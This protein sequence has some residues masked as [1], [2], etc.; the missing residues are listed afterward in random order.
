MLGRLILLFTLVPLVEL[1]LLIKIGT[2]IGALP[3]VLIVVGTG[4]L[5]AYLSRQQGFMVWSRIQRE[6]EMGMFP[7]E[8]MLDGLLIFG[9]GVVLLTPGVITDVIGILILIP[10]TRLY[11]REWIKRRLQIMMDR[12]NV[13]FNG[14]LR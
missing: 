9:A 13:H 1:F 2:I 10:F 6:M 14:F 5:G 8:D 11:I 4:V 7:A 3:T 12:G